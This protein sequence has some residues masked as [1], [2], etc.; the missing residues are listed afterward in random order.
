MKKRNYKEITEERYDELTDINESFVKE[1]ELIEIHKELVDTYCDDL[2]GTKDCCIRFTS[3][4]LSKNLGRSI[5]YNYPV[6][7]EKFIKSKYLSDYFKSEIS[8][9]LY[10][11]KI[12]DSVKNILKSDKHINDMSEEEISQISSAIKEYYEN[13]KHDNDVTAASLLSTYLYKLNGEGVISYIKKNVNSYDLATH[14]LY[15]S[16]LNPRASYYSG[17]GVNIGDLN[18]KNLEKIFHELLKLDV[19]Y[20]IEYVKMVMQMETLGA[21]EFINTFFNF[22]NNNFKAEDL[23][24]DNNNVSLDGAYG[25]DR[26]IIAAASIFSLFGR[27]NDPNGQ[28]MSSDSMKRSFIYKI[29]PLLKELSPELLETLE[30]SDRVSNKYDRVHRHSKKYN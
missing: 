4:I 2:W 7:I 16:G 23:K 6:E 21:T 3:N 10:G 22:A 27:E 29:R 17:R 14:I 26:D 30:K 11:T 18:E 15:V 5:V 12:S 13:P 9:L 8:R 19:A 28:K 24:I 20:A 1:K 25:V